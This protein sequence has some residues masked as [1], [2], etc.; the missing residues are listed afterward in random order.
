M[1][2]TCVTAALSLTR[3]IPPL[4]CSDHVRAKIGCSPIQCVRSLVVRRHGKAIWSVGNADLHQVLA[5]VDA[6]ALLEETEA[7]CIVSATSDLDVWRSIRA[8]SWCTALDWWPE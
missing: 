6:A 4:W 1:R 8:R 3:R 7:S 2:V 5:R